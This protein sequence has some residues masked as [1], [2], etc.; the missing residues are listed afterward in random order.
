MFGLAWSTVHWLSWEELTSSQY[1]VVL[2][3]NVEID[4]TLYFTFLMV[5]ISFGKVHYHHFPYIFWVDITNFGEG[6]GPIRISN[7]LCS[8]SLC[9]TQR[10]ASN[11]TRALKK[12]AFG[13]WPKEI[14]ACYSAGDT[15]SNFLSS[16][17]LLS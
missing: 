1:W 8:I 4:P 6:T 15:R 12:N 2:F 11:I 9:G 16:H 13:I 10:W 7:S 14:Q 5:N 17:V 3:V